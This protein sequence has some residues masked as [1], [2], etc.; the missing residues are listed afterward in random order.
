[1]KPSQL[2]RQLSREV[3]ITESGCWKHTGK[4][5]ADGYRQTTYQGKKWLAHRLSYTILVGPIPDGAVLDHICHVPGECAGGPRC[6][7]RMCLNPT[8]LVPTT[9]VANTLRGVSANKAAC[10]H[11]H[12][13]TPENTV[14][15]VDKGRYYRR[16]R[17]CLRA[18]GR[19]G[20]GRPRGERHPLARITD[21]EVKH[22]LELGRLGI[23]VKDI[24]VSAGISLSYAYKILNGRARSD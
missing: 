6:P 3:I 1:M 18:I 19:T 4:P 13:Y 21:S 17:E 5:H 9:I 2:P 16:C 8:H 12:A 23:P 7:H 10:V 22:I 24:A 15:R 11:G 20:E 14:I